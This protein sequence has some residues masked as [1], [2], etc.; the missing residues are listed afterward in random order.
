MFVE[1]LPVDL[2]EQHVGLQA[3][4]GEDSAAD[5]GLAGANKPIE[6]GGRRDGGRRIVGRHE[7]PDGTEG[8]CRGT[9]V[10]G[11]EPELAAKLATRGNAFTAHRGTVPRDA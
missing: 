7:A 8:T 2:P 3:A 1:D 10:G 9:G 4:A 5:V 6:A 11:V